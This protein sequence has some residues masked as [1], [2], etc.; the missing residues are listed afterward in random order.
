MV[1]GKGWESSNERGNDGWELRS[2]SKY[3]SNSRGWVGRVLKAHLKVPPGPHAKGKHEH[4]SPLDSKKPRNGCYLRNLLLKTHGLGRLRKL[5][6]KH[7]F[8]NRWAAQWVLGK[9]DKT[10]P[11][12]QAKQDSP[13]I[14]FSQSVIIIVEF[15]ILHL[16]YLHTYFNY[17]SNERLKSDSYGV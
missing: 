6:Q 8:E 1:S 17:Q 9:P 5:R 2:E 10:L 14:G 4:S 16:K 12:N 13:E 3:S 7:G 11:Q 15:C